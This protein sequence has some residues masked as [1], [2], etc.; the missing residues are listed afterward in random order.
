MTSSF[1]CFC[2]HLVLLL[3]ARGKQL[4]YFKREMMQKIRVSPHCPTHVI[5]V[6]PSSGAN[7]SVVLRSNNTILHHQLQTNKLLVNN[8]ALPCQRK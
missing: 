7:V 5:H 2:L 1:S 3:L 6:R 4:H 8:I